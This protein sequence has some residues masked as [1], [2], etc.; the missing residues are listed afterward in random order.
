MDPILSN[1]TEE[2][3]RDIA[4]LFEEMN[5]T[6]TNRMNTITGAVVDVACVVHIDHEDDVKCEGSFVA[7][8]GLDPMHAFV[9]L[10]QGLVTM[11][12]IIESMPEDGERGEGEDEKDTLH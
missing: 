11:Q 3:R 10:T 8:N 6:I 2:Q 9:V 7:T 4:K 5:I 1:L 12:K